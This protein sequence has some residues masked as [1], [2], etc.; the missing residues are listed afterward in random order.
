M[1]KSI[2]MFHLSIPI[3]DGLSPMFHP[4][5]TKPF[6]KRRSE[7]WISS[8]ME[9]Q[10]LVFQ[11]PEMPLDQHHCGR[12]H[13]STVLFMGKLTISTRPKNISGYVGHY[14]R[15]DRF[16]IFLKYTDPSYAGHVPRFFHKAPDQIQGPVAPKLQQ[17]TTTLSK[18]VRKLCSIRL[19]LVG[20]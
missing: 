14:Q 20:G 4:V 19:N 17:D 13:R 18:H 5:P 16:E 9:V 1:T 6:A 7:H 10:V 3:C 8:I 2:P 12:I 15:V 11:S